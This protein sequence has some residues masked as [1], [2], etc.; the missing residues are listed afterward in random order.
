MPV[1]VIEFVTVAHPYFLVL[2]QGSDLKQRPQH[3]FEGRFVRTAWL[4]LFF[5]YPQRTKQDMKLDKSAMH[6]PAATLAA[7][8][9][10]CVPG[11][12]Q[13]QLTYVTNNGTITITGY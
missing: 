4:S 6:L 8:L 12:V 2:H 11:V 9:I 10:V 7:L 3:G 5:A 1:I 13:A